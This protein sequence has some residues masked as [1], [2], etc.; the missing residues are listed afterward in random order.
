MSIFFTVLDF[1]GDHFI[2]ICST[3]VYI[4]LGSKKS[5]LTVV[6]VIRCRAHF[7]LRLFD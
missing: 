1:Y 7:I 3:G 5:R 6:T 2:H 4:R